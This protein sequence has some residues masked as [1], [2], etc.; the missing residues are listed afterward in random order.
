M[1]TLSGLVGVILF[2]FWQ[3]APGNLNESSSDEASVV[4]TS[5]ATENIATE[6]IAPVMIE[7]N[8]SS[9]IAIEDSGDTA[10]LMGAI[11][12]SLNS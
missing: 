12:K 2:V 1:F 5:A 10:S 7:E 11:A 6:N 4:N 9:A 8:K 3:F